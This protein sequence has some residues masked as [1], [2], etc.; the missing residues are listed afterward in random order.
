MGHKP[1][2]RKTPTSV[3]EGRKDPVCRMEFEGPPPFTVQHLGKPYAL[4]SRRCARL[5]EHA[6]YDYLDH[7]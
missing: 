2:F 7:P 3:L 4:C 1:N 5:F 6:P